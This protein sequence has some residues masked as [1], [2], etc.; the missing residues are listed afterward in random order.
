M[1]TGEKNGI[2]EAEWFRLVQE[3]YVGSPDFL[4]EIDKTLRVFPAVSQECGEDRVGSKVILDRP[5]SPANH[6]EETPDASSVKL[7]IDC[8][9]KR[10]QLQAV[11]GIGE[12]REHFLWYLLGERKHSRSHSSS[13]YDRF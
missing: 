2:A 11:S 7:L 9:D 1:S 12:Y 5:L 6:N 4:V 3:D 10:L 13:S 8:L